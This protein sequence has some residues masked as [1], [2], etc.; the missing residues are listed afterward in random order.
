VKAPKPHSLVGFTRGLF[1]SCLNL[2]TC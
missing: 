1:D 2:R